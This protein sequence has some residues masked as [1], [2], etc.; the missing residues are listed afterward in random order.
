VA[1]NALWLV[2]LL[3]YI[4]TKTLSETFFQLRGL[5]GLLAVLVKPGNVPALLLVLLAIIG[6]ARLARGRRREV[7]CAPAAGAV[8][9]L[10]VAA[11]GV[12]LPFFNQLEPGRFLVPAL[13]FMAPLAGAGTV[14]VMGATRAAL[15]A[16]RRS[17][18]LCASVSITLLLSAPV[19]SLASSRAFFRHTLTTTFT[20][21]SRT[22]IDE[23]EKR[24]GPSGRLMIED[25]PAWS[26]G[27]TFL[28]ALLPSFTGVEQIGGPYPFTFIEH[29][30]AA[31]QTCKAFGRDLSKTDAAGFRAYLD[32]YN[33][34]WIL[35]ATPECAARIGELVGTA[36]T[37]SSGA[38]TLWD[39]SSGSTF[40]SVPGVNVTATLGRI[41]VTIAPKV[42][43]PPPERIFLKY[44]W[45]PGLETAPPARISPEKRLDDPV[46]F[47]LLEPRGGRV[48]TINYK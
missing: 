8:F 20:P 28:P 42:G 40:A 46:P 1:L 25:G 44:H 38:F 15:R 7:V 39:I 22:L 30:F 37:W 24:T 11:F 33:V 45:D 34:H 2:P 47:I 21:A 12:Y 23:L 36:S 31:F 19:L 10:F 43:E 35:A 27:D 9:L 3:R 32:L 48:V 4:R 13:I 16:P 5:G 41:V 17:A 29:H 14:A 6:F 18:A 26:Y